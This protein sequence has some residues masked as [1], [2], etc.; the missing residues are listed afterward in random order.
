MSTKS[1]YRNIVKST[2]VFGSAQMV[3]VLI[4]LLR[5]K[6]VAVFLGSVG[7]G[8]NTLL[9]NA[10]ST[11]Q[12]FA[13][14][15]INTIS[16]RNISSAKEAGNKDVL[17]YTIQLVR[18]LML[19]AA[20]VGLLLM[21]VASPLLS[22]FSFGESISTRL[23]LLLSVVVFLNILGIGEYII[24]QGMRRYRLLA[25]ASVATPL[26]SLLIGVP[27]YWLMGIRGILPAMLAVSFLYFVIVHY[28]ARRYATLDVP[29]PHITLRQAWTEGRS[30]IKLGSIM[31]AASLLGMLTTYSI[32]AFISNTGSLSDVGLYQ[33]ANSITMQYIG[34]VFAAMAAD[35]YPHLA[36]KI[37]HNTS[38][39]FR[40]VNQQI[41]IVQLIIVPLTLFVIILAPL[42]IQI[43]LTDEFS[44]ICQIIRFMAVA[45]VLRAFCFPMD[46]IALAKGDMKYFFWFEGVANNLKNLIIIIIFYHLYGLQGLGYAALIT[47]V[48]D[49]VA[50]TT[51]VHWRYGFTLSQTTVRLVLFLLLIVILCFLAT[52]LPVS[53]WVYALEAFLAI[54]G[55]WYCYRQLDRRIDIRNL[56]HSALH[57]KKA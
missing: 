9:N 8:I 51:L 50:S 44:P 12:E 4:N 29:T 17:Q 57:R 16:V 11:V 36:G 42:I 33:A 30:I 31:M 19:L 3:N 21:L 5:G 38:D 26:F 48:I 55:S 24:L 43:L 56:F 15:G 54:F 27:I 52:F 7:I 45:G 41:E 40:L 14:L 13:M 46:Y 6:L 18:K 1:A 39:A 25:L 34:M 22:R 47:S 10:A 28:L 53:P 23:F 49:I 32:S 37:E 35:Y 20:M 2:A